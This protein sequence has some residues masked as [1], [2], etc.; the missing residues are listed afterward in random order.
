MRKER[1]R[2]GV[3]KLLI[4]ARKR[5]KREEIKEGK[6][7]KIEYGEGGGKC[8]RGTGHVSVGRK[9][10]GKGKYIR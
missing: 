5:G 10:E 7:S 9:R 6:R 3:R 1:G 2:R 8:K 4:C